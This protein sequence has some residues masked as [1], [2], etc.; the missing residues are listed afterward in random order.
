MKTILIRCVAPSAMIAAAIG[1][2]ACSSPSPERA[3]QTAG[4][5]VAS[6]DRVTLPARGYRE[7]AKSLADLISAS[8]NCVLASY[9]GRG[10]DYWPEKDPQ[11]DVFARFEMRIDRVLAGDLQTGATITLLLPGGGMSAWGDP[12]PGGSFKPKPGQHSVEVTYADHPFPEAGRS[13]LLCLEDLVIEESGIKSNVFVA[14]PD[15]RFAVKN[16]RLQPLV[17]AEDSSPAVR[18]ALSG[19]TVDNAAQ[20]IAM[21][22][23][24]P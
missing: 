15:A 8:G 3:T 7:P 20:A 14:N 13:E 19:T 9:L 2:A 22:G 17:A 5:V 23:S 1:L 16:G 10:A 21:A 11:I 4:E 18:A 24:M 12:S 6:T